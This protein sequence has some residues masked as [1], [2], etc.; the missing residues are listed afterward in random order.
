MRLV[1]RVLGGDEQEI[2]DIRH[3]H[4]VGADAVDQ[5]RNFYEL[6]VQ[7]G[8]IPDEISL[9]RAEFLLAQETNDW[10]L[11]VVGN[12]EQG[13]AEPEVRIIPDARHQLIVKPP[14]SVTLAGVRSAKALRFSFRRRESDEE[15]RPSHDA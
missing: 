12:V 5:L 1:R 14:G 4:N 8:P 11:V 2:V 9:T 3:Q 13:N 15:P 7:S 10:F 6:K